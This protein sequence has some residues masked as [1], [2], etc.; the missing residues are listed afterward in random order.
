MSA[1]K[2]EPLITFGG[3][4]ILD[5]GFVLA[6]F[7][8]LHKTPTFLFGEPALPSAIDRLAAIE[9]PEIAKRVAKMDAKHEEWKED[10]SPAGF[11]SRKGLRTRHK[12]IPVRPDFFTQV[13]VTSL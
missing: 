1:A 13:D 7:V 3:G 12:K 2:P 6:P 11:S 8:P 5:A 4:K 9:D 10:G